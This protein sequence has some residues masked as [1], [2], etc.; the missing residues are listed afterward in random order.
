M[1][2]YCGLVVCTPGSFFAV[3]IAELL[4]FVVNSNH[5][6]PSFLLFI[7]PDAPVLGGGIDLRVQCVSGVVGGRCGPEVGFAVVPAVMVDVVHE[8]P[9]RDV[10]HFAVHHNCEA[11]F[12]FGRPL[13]PHGV[14]RIAPFADVPFVAVE[15]VEIVGVH[16]GVFSL[17]EADASESVAVT[18]L[19]VQE[20]RQHGRHFQPGRD[21]DFDGELDDFRTHPDEIS[22]LKIQI[23]KLHSKVKNGIRQG[24]LVLDG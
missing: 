3:V 1:I 15:A 10:E 21:S 24:R 16:D 7:V 19:S 12:Q 9:F 8:E 18:Q 2:A 17:R 6:P 4:S 13:A 5:G 23:S 22:N 20:H 14:V 11:L